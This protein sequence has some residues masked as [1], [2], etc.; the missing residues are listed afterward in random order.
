[1][2][3]GGSQNG[4]V[5]WD[6]YEAYPVLL[7][8]LWHFIHHHGT[9]T[10]LG[11]QAVATNRHLVTTVEQLRWLRACLTADTSWGVLL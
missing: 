5:V 7:G 2:K 8:R 6:L 3:R 1:M 4:R 11:R 10:L 9:P